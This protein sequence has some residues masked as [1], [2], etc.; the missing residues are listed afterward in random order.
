MIT[1]PPPNDRP[2]TLNATHATDASTPPPAASTKA[3]AA[4]N[5]CSLAP[6][7]SA[8]TAAAA[9]AVPRLGVTAVRRAVALAPPV[10]MGAVAGQ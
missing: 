8:V 5:P 10:E 1:N 2:P 7:P 3:G 6:P 4:R 9:A